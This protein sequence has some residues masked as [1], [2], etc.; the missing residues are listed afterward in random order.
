MSVDWMWAL[1][2]V[3]LIRKIIEMIA[4]MPSMCLYVCVCVCVWDER[5]GR[6][7]TLAA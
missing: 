2:R 1:A 3:T 7:S 5:G 6:F 4:D